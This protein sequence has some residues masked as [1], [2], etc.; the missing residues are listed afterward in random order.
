[1]CTRCSHEDADAPQG[2]GYN[3]YAMASS[4][5]NCSVCAR[6]RDFSSITIKCQA[7]TRS[8]ISKIAL[9]IVGWHAAVGGTDCTRMG[10]LALTG[11]R[12]P[13][14]LPPT[15]PF[16]C[17]DLSQDAVALPDRFHIRRYEQNVPISN[18]RAVPCGQRNRITCRHHHSIRR[19]V[20]EWADTCQQGGDC[21]YLNSLGQR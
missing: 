16:C 14:V 12:F 6:E 4:H 17:Y 11:R 9:A 5:N 21:D 20:A 10:R 19:S 2:R 3:I 13:K 1:M 15:L 7:G 8:G 18:S